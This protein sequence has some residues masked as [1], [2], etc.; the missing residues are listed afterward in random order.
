MCRSQG[1][2]TDLSD[3]YLLE[4]ILIV[5]QIVLIF[6]LYDYCAFIEAEARIIKMPQAIISAN[7]IT[8]ILADS[9]ILRPPSVLY[10]SS[11][12]RIF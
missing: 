9:K 5:T 2:L 8:G 3:I 7:L 11:A 6:N 12:N 4:L 10:L 1:L